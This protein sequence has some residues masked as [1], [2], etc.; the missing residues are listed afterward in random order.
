MESVSSTS[1]WRARGQGI[2][3]FLLA[4]T[5]TLVA[6]EESAQTRGASRLPGY[7]TQTA[8]RQGEIRRSGLEVTAGA[9]ME[10]VIDP[11]EY[12]VGPYDVFGVVIYTLSEDVLKIPVSPEGS[13]L[14]PGIGEQKVAGFTLKAAKEKILSAI[15][16]VFKVGEPTIALAAPREFVV[17]VEGSVRNPGPYLMPS[18]LRLDKAIAMANLVNEAN[19]S[20]PS[21]WSGDFSRR[22]IVIRHREKPDRVVDL[23]LFYSKGRRDQNPF[24]VEGDLI[25]VPPKS[26]NQSSVSVYGA[27]NQP[28]QFEYREYDSL[29][30]LIRM[31][32]GFTP[33]ADP[34]T[35][36]VSEF[37]LNAEDVAVRTVDVGQIMRGERP[38]IPVKNKSRILVRE[39]VDRRR[40]FKV[41]VRGEIMFPG[42]YAI[43]PDS[44]RLSD[45]I[46]RA[47]GFTEYAFLPAAEVERKQ[48]TLAGENIDLSMES[49]LNRRMNDQLVAP[50]EQAYY[51]MESR[52]R[53]GVVTVDF[54][55]L[56]L[57]KDPAADIMLEDGDVI[58]VPNTTKTVYVLGQVPKPGYAAF[59]EGA[60]LDYYIAQAGGYGDE[61]EEGETRIIKIKTREWKNPSDTII[62]PGDTIWI[63]K[64][65][66]YTFAYYMNVISQAAGFI[67]VV[68]SMTV[69]IIQL[70]RNN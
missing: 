1:Q 49:M 30:A 25:Y 61:A 65:T 39:R 46:R 2:C 52:L 5:V 26:I 68:L 53:R 47:G 37:S 22:N 55:K 19:L 10:E 40:D 57:G 64:E 23:D 3:L 12:I 17:T 35:V 4:C 59:K 16:S 41:H 48:L 51:E 45:V 32:N 56:F 20:Q 7:R 38:D 14:I 21:K 6:Q 33:N 67:S 27:V 18:T 70:T 60:S 50:E 9:P 62:E 43:T 8:T 44:T 34:S 69:I 31:A 13:V 42:M 11:E 63:P 24:L 58:Y 15:K 28:S 29:Y 54:V 66:R 36:E